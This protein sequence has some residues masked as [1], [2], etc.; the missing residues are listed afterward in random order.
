MAISQA[1][2]LRKG[3]R[4]TETA[5]V[6]A[7]TR[8]SAIV[9]MSQLA[10]AKTPSAPQTPAANLQPPL[11][12]V[13]IGPVSAAEIVLPSES[14]VAYSPMKRAARVGKRA[15]MK[16][17]TRAPA[18]AMPAPTPAVAAKSA[19]AVVEKARSKVETN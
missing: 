12:C 10:T 1:V 6:G 4:W 7:R 11:A 5:P 18:I 8:L 16:P 13:A 2:G 17:P 15:L 14:E 19:R 9:T 3:S